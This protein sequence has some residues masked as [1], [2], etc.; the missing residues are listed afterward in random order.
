LSG[1]PVA[2]LVSVILIVLQIAFTYAP[3]MQYLF[4]S[5]A[6]DAVSWAVILGFA[7]VLFLAVEIEKAVLRGARV[8]RL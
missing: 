6:L 7:S 1:N 2:L 8:L 4:H 3:P 5:V